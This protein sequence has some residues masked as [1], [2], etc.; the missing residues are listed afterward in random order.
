MHKII[1]EKIKP[2]KHVNLRMI[3]RHNPACNLIYLHEVDKG[4]HFAA[5]EQPELFAIELRAAFRSLR[6]AH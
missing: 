2:K 3:L 1:I 4:G 5:W 6:S